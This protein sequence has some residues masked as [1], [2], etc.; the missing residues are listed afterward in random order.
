[1]VGGERFKPPS[2]P[3]LPTP[4]SEPSPP[5]RDPKNRLIWLA[6]FFCRP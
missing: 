1:M 5:P 3:P 6:P 2:R 4:P